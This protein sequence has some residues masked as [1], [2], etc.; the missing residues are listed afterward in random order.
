MWSA[1]AR[2]WSAR[3][4]R[5]A[6]HPSAKTARSA[7]PWQPRMDIA[8]ASDSSS[9]AAGRSASV[10][11]SAPA[12]AATRSVM[13][14]PASERPP[15]GRRA[16]DST[17]TSGRRSR[18]CR[19]SCSCRMRSRRRRS[20][21][22]SIRAPTGRHGRDVHHLQSQPRP[23][24]ARNV[25]AVSRARRVERLVVVAYRM[26]VRDETIRSADVQLSQHRH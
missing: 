5:P 3:R 11:A 22:S 9:P 7:R 13:M 4:S 18:R 20:T 2:T 14:S 23:Q 6:T 17:S 8:T 12:S 15:P 16:R 26:N 19:C 24:R 25:E 1:P 21:S 10:P